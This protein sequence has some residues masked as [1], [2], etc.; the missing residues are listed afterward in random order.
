VIVFY[1]LILFAGNFSEPVVSGAFLERA[2]C[3]RARS[4]VEAEGGTTSEC[5]GVQ[6]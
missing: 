4:Y 3:E 2:T 1:F 5:Y 6:K